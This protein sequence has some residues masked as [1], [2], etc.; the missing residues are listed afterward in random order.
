MITTLAFDIYGT[1]INTQGVVSELHKIIG[2][3]A[4]EFSALWRNKQLEYSFRRGLMH[5]YKD[6]SICTRDA[7]NYACSFFDISC[8]EAQKKRLLDI[9]Q[10]LP[11]FNDVET[12]LRLLKHESYS[13][14]A[15]SNGTEE[16]VRK[17][18][19]NT[20]L[21]SLFDGIVSVDAVQSFKPD[22]K[23]YLHFLEATQSKLMDVWLV[24]SNPFDVIGAISSG[25]K[26]IWIKRDERST[27]DPWGIEPTITITSLL[28]IHNSIV[29]FAAKSKQTISLK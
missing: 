23:V 24:S 28:K 19:I 18:L 25:M 16:A 14:F 17:L 27:F 7:F 29:D 20:N 6:F 3:K 22:P 8:T 1:L 12:A 2:K 13:I 15:F 5:E 10:V 4:E 21:D 26:A 11:A 9:Y